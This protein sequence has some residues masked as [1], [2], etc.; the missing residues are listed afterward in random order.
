MAAGV[1]R[2]E[3]ASSG[4]TR[5]HLPLTDEATVKFRLSQAGSAELKVPMDS[6]AGRQ[7][8]KSDSVSDGWGYVLV[9]RNDTLMQVL[10]TEVTEVGVRDGEGVPVIGISATESPYQRMDGVIIEPSKP[11][12]F[13]T[14][15]GQIGTRLKTLIDANTGWGITCATPGTTV[16][17]DPSVFEQGITLLSFIQAWAFRASGFDFRFNPEFTVS[18]AGFGSTGQFYC[19][20]TIGE[21][22]LNAKFEFGAGS[23][24]NLSAYSWKRFGGQ[25]LCNIADVPS[26]GTS[27]GNAVGLK[28]AADVTSVATYGIRRRWITADFEDATLRQNLADDHVAFRKN[29]R[30]V[31][32]ITPMPETTPTAFVDYS[33]GDIVPVSITDAGLSVINGNVRIYGISVTIDKNGME[34]IELETSPE[35]A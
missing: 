13:P 22:K 25:H 1:W 20:S 31:L 21:I 29:P 32:S 30:R 7:I 5:W 27:G 12:L 28:T 15:A 18:G 26:N 10:E 11:Y 8:A 6:A 4:G 34:K 33:V 19:A 23:K 17:V 35:T 16:S 14:T 9:Y 24:T 3:W 2:F